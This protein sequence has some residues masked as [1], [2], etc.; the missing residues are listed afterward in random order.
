MCKWARGQA[1]VS[2]ITLCNST[3]VINTGSGAAGFVDS[4]YWSSSENG[5]G[6]AWL[7]YFDDGGQYSGYTGSTYYV[8]PVRAF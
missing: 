8:R 2:D 6:G 5:A 4:G 3:G 1:W 7:Q